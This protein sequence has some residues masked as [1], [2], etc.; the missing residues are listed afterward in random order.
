M[1][2][3]QRHTQTH[4]TEGVNF[5]QL[6]SRRWSTVF[7]YIPVGWGELENKNWLVDG[8]ARISSWEE[9]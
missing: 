3:I 2:L 7:V 1:Y 9:M 6:V 5:F 8:T 4:T